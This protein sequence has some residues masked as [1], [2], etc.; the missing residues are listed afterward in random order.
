MAYK[1]KEKFLERDG[2]TL[3]YCHIDPKLGQACSAHIHP[4]DLDLAKL[5]AKR[6]RSLGE[7]LISMA[8]AAEETSDFVTPDEMFKKL[9]LGKPKSKTP[10]EANAWIESN[11]EPTTIL[12]MKTSDGVWLQPNPSFGP[13][14]CQDCGGFLEQRILNTGQKVWHHTGHAELDGYYDIDKNPYNSLGLVSNMFDDL[15]KSDI[16]IITANA[17]IGNTYL[18]QTETTYGPITVGREWGTPVNETAHASYP[19]NCC[20]DCGSQSLKKVQRKNGF[21]KPNLE[22]TVCEN[23][24]KEYSL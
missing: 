1:S 24:N 7:E 23:C 4:A 9:G 2:K 20:P 5:D 8:D 16:D 14:K 15:D 22:V 12:P 3:S 10:A 11:S 13:P 21:R 18:D 17:A 19:A 6:L